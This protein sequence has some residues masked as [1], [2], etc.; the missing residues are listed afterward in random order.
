M[1]QQ[2]KTQRTRERILA[3]AVSEFGSKSY[4]AASVNSICEAGQI[5]KGLFYHNFK[6]KDD[7]YL[8][9]VKICYD[10]MTDYLQEQR[11]E[12][13]DAEESLKKFL[14]I[15]QEFFEQH[16]DYA[17]IFF[18]AVL[19]PPKHLTGELA[20]L[21][22]EFD[23][24]FSRRYQ[25]ILQCITLREG[26]TVNVALEYFSAVWEMFNGYFRKK[27]DMRGDYHELIQAH[28]S[29]LSGIFDIMLYGIAEKK[30]TVGNLGE[31]TGE[32]K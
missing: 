22:R 8:Q 4:D 26:I 1:K 5:S 16:P 14:L 32:E 31:R 7:L 13:R 18:N 10:Q 25:E 20:E 2:E 6:N 9:C 24:Y 3:A 15:R 29:R 23:D 11:F 27:A 19:Q 21:R 17:N 28:E 12:I 30:E